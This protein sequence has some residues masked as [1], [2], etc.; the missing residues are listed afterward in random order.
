MTRSLV[1]ILALG[2]AAVSVPADQADDVLRH[3]EWRAVGPAGAGGRIVD[4]AVGGGARQTIYVA[5][6]TGGIWK[7]TSQGTAWHPIFDHQ[8]VASVGAVAVDPSN[9][10]IVWVGTGEVNPRNSVSWGDGVYRSADGGRTW[11]H[12]GLEDSRHIG[13]IV[14]D[15][16][17][18]SVV[19]VAALG[20]L[21]GSSRQRGVFKTTDGGQ[22][23]AS[24]LFVN[25]DTGAV[26]LVM[27]PRDSS[28]LYA[29]AYEVR[30]DGFAGGDPE[31]GWGPGSGIYKTT[32]AGR[33]WRK[34]TDGLPAGPLGRIGLA[35]AA[36]NP[37]FVY[38]VVQT[39]TT[40]PRESAE[41]GPAPPPAGPRT[42][43]DGGIFRSEDR[44]ETWQWVNA[45]D[46]RPFYYSQV[47]V[48][49]AN[50][51]HLF[52]L[53][54]SN[55]ESDDGGRTFRTLNVNIHVDHHAM[56]IDPRDS[57]H[58]IDGN[59]GGIYV[60]W[61]GGAT[62][63][64]QNQMALSQLYSVDLDM[65]KPYFIYG[66]SQDYC[67]WGGPSATPKSVGIRVDDW[68]RVQTGDGFQARV[69]PA[70]YTIVYAES[71]NGGLVRHDLR[72]G[73]NVAIKP[74]ARTGEP[75]Y[76]FNWET[77]V[78]ISS[79]DPKTIYVGG[80]RLFK[81]TD[82]GDAWTPVSPDL[83]TDKAGTITTFAESPLDAAVLYAGTDDGHVW[84]TR[85]G[86][87][88][89]KE[90]TAR[91]PNMP[92]RRWVSR[93]V[94]SKYDAG[95]VYLAFDG[96]RSD[97]VTTYLFKSTDFGST[98]K[99]IRSDLPAA[100]PV[101]VIREDVRNPHLLFAGTEAAAYTSWD[102]GAH[103]HRLMNGMPTVPV[104]D[105][106]VHP[107]D[108]ELVAATHGRS[109]F[110]MDIAPLEEL[111]PAVLAA[112]AHLFAVKSAVAYDYRAF[113]DDQF[114]GEKR[115]VGENP[116]PGTTISYYLK[117]AKPDVRLAV[118]DKAGAVVRELTAT[119]D[120]GINRVQW[121]LRGK[122][123]ASGRGEPGQTGGA[124]GAGAAG[125]AGEAGAPGG[126]GTAGRA[127]Q[128]GRGGG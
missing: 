86:G 63:D 94:A 83:T 98:W 46:L 13:R 78:L 10:D 57:R 50:E 35:V 22:T 74:R 61:D 73:R 1:F 75:A 41:E 92:G 30:R 64:F 96:H 108:G 85:N 11:A 99:S 49:P 14:V 51:R 44:G 65:R 77:P 113:S 105:L 18:P 16:R 88:E 116:P 93:L 54:T 100:T 3:F 125:R 67:S 80:N 53:G 37:A 27:D 55:S 82:R 36:S 6:A 120:A 12:L 40:V 70:D 28:T 102:D 58:I 119:R 87:T 101:R 4:I 34:M 52:V 103:W 5:A 68:Y 38:A 17:N 21:W 47:R 20:H 76:R 9:A 59:D 128:A 115:F 72:T 112:D 23:W 48:D 43:A 117:S 123:L 56:W 39:A 7:S 91:V 69:D 97:D 33:T 71:Q 26:D 60:T 95:T 114:L 106:A 19:Y 81:S 107:R 89:W 118:I 45:L 62:W 111:T 124:R 109:F 15:P 121:D 104:A 90:I 32:D 126:T 31:K 110:V 42:M 25:D 24:S 2:A 8:D 84:A 29:A 66:G 79:H 127:G 122:G